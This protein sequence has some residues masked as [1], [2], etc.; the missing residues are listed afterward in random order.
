MKKYVTIVAAFVVATSVPA[1]A[2]DRADSKAKEQ[3]DAFMTFVKDTT[4]RGK[5]QQDAFEVSHNGGMNYTFDIT[6]DAKGNR[7]LFKI[8]AAQ[9]PAAG[10]LLNLVPSIA[11]VTGYVPGL[12]TMAPKEIILH[13][14]SYEMI[15]AKTVV[16]DREG[17]A[18]SS[19]P[20]V[21][22]GKSGSRLGLWVDLMS[23]TLREC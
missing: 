15:V 2:E 6:I 23:K 10:R 21:L 4:N 17:M 1:M 22:K 13:G 3:S 5:G 18:G 16:T 11:S 9:C 8:T 14:V 20:L 7:K 19:Y 12:N